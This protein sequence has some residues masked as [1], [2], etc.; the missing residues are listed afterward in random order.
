MVT[1]SNS[2]RKRVLNGQTR[3]GFHWDQAMSE[4]DA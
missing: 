2:E 4:V 3:F 1:V